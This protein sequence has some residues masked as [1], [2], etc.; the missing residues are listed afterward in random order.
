VVS[1]I[2][3]KAFSDRNDTLLEKSEQHLYLRSLPQKEGDIFILEDKES[4][5]CIVILSETPDYLRATLEIRY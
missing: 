2:T 3:L 4:G 1:Y 5:N